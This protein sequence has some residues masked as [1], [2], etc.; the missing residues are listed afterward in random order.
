MIVAATGFFDG[1]HNGHRMVIDKAVEMAR[2]A[3]GKSM[4]VTF[5]PHPRNALQLDADKLRLLTS[6]EE[7]RQRCLA[8]GVNEFV[9]LPF[10][11][12]FSNLTAS[13]FLSK[14]LIGRYGV[15]HLVLGYDHH[16]GSD[17]VRD[18]EAMDRIVRLCGIVPIRVTDSISASG[19]PVS[20]TMIRERLSAGDVV[21]GNG[22]LGYRYALE[23]AVV[24]GNRIGRTLGFPTAN[25]SLYEPLK[26][27]PACG[28]YLVRAT[29]LGQTFTGLC[30]IGTR[31]TLADGRGQI[32]EVHLLDFDEEIYG[33][34]LRIEFVSRLRDERRFDSLEDLRKQLNKD[35][36][37]ARKFEKNA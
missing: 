33:L 17:D 36:A 31:P 23:G 37:T 28:V 20:S 32:I 4:I 24:A 18:T 12:D 1:V 14:Y 27:V 22:L 19:R 25:L 7:K 29:V 10:T 9:V 34:D 21:L 2:A 3:G 11:R 8:L 13:E 30:N 16:L 6:L 35:L 15:T 5:W 26:L